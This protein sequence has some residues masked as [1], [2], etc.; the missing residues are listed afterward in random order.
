MTAMLDMALAGLKAA[1]TR[2]AIRADN[3]ANLRTEGF[4]PAA[5]V[6]TATAAGP[7]VRA[8]R[9]G[10]PQ[11]KIPGT[12]LVLA[13]TGIEEDLVDI[14]LSKAAYKSS[15]ALIRTQDELFETLLDIRS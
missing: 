5:P 2:L 7:V 9:T 13:T 11:A 10:P 14:T 4:R 6:Q 3:L 8:V 15:A 12:D 1:S